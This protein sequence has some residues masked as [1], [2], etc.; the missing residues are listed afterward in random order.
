MTIAEDG[1]M[2]QSGRVNSRSLPLLALGAF[3]ALAVV[4]LILPLTLPIGPMYWD[5]LVYY[6]AIGR[7]NAGQWPIL[8]FMIPAGPLEYYLVWLAERFFGAAHPVVLTQLA[9]LPVTVPVMAAIVWDVGRRNPASAW[10]LLL[11]F[12]L[13]SLLPFNLLTYNEF[14]GTDAY[15][16]YNRH[17]SH[18]MYL[19]AA[20]VL[21]V[22]AR[23]M[24]T[25]LLSVLLLS[26]ALCKITAF[27]AVGPL[28]ILGLLTRH[29]AVPVAAVTA[30]LCL[31]VT[32][33]LEVVTGM[34]S[35]YLLVLA[36]LVSANE[37]VLISRFLT[38]IS[39]RFD[40][41][42]AGA[43]LGGAL[44]LNDLRRSR[45]GAARAGTDA[46][47]E[48]GLDRDWIWL[49]L[50]LLCGLFFETQNT[51]S[52]PYLIVWPVLLRI[53]LREAAAHGRMRLAVLVLVAAMAL[54]VVSTMLHKAARAAALAPRYVALNQPVLGPLG[55]VS[56]KDVHIEQAERMRTIYLF[57]PETMRAIA[58]TGS[59]PSFRMFSEH[60]YQYLLL[61]EMGVAAAAVL[62]LEARS[63]TR[64]DTVFTVD[65]ANPFPYVLQRPGAAHVMIGA[66]PSRAVPDP[67]ERTLDAV[68][69]TDLI[70]VPK[71]PV[72]HARLQ[73]QDLYTPAL[74]GRA[75]VALT[76]CYDALLKPDSPAAALA[77]AGQ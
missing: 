62:D 46:G 20:T 18:L 26:L 41:L 44:I 29:I 55:R 39:L 9:W 53:L 64:F 70:L 36:D 15:G 42:A 52:H 17:G 57:H 56:A 7:M 35:G 6:D 1:R 77:E 24:Q 48:T 19:T 21:F 61:Q 67:D 74:E 5:V 63:G 51:G 40:V 27:V 22:R 71:C 16:I 13:F 25:V 2:A 33:L 23:A 58:E 28:L 30:A 38:A 68:A 49:G 66:D 8:D 72:H 12:M 59:L 47:R 11:P 50:A 45:D 32:A 31:A 54:P 60:D 34:V 37:S 73:L 69:N 65:F 75:K 4:L 43:L 14:A 76:P 3:L 10:G